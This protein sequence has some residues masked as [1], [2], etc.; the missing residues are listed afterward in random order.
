MSKYTLDFEGRKLTL[1]VADRWVKQAAG[2]VIA[3]MGETVVL[4]AATY[5]KA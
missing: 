1:E 3:S 5:K 4:A 2:A